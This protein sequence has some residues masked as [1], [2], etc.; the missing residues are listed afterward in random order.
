MRVRKRDG[1]LE[2][3][4]LDKV[5]YRL[6]TLSGN[7]KGLG[8]LSNIDPDI[9]ALDVVSRLYDSIPTTQIDEEAA[10]IAVSRTEH[11]E[12]LALASRIIISNSHRMTEECFSAVMEMLYDNVDELGDHFPI[13]NKDFI[14]LVRKH[15][16][17]LNFIPDYQLD[18]HLD[19]FGFK[20][21]ER[22]YLLK[23]KIKRGDKDKLELLPL[24]R[25][26]HMYLRVALALYR[27]DL[28]KVERAY[29]YMS[30]GLYTQA[31]PTMFNAGTSL[32]QLSSCFDED[33]LV[34]TTNRGAVKIKDICIGDKTITHT[35]KERKITQIH[36]NELNNREMYR[37]KVAKTKHVLVTGNHKLY[38]YNEASQEITWKAVEN[39]ELHDYVCTVLNVECLDVETEYGRMKFLKYE[40]KEIIDYKKQYVYT[41]GVEEDHS[42]TVEG[43]IVENCFLLHMEDSLEGIFKTMTDTALIS[44]SAGGIG[45]PISNIRAKGSFIR[46]TNGP[47]DGIIPM[48]KVFN[49]VGKYVNQGGKRKGSIALYVE[50]WHGD[51]FEFLDLRK[52]QGHEDLRARDLFLALWIPDLFMKQ[53]ESDGDWWL[54]CPDK[55]PGLTECYGDEFEE[56]YWKYVKDLRFIKKIKAQEL[57]K[58]ILDAQIETGN[59]YMVY[60]DAVNRKSNQKNIGMVKSSNLCVHGDTEILTDRGYF[61]IESLEGQNVKVWNGEEWSATIILKTGENQNLSKIVFSDGGHLVCTEYHKFYVKENDKEIQVSAYELKEGVELIRCVYPILTKEQ[62]KNDIPNRQE[63]SILV[64][65]IEKNYTV[66]DTYC[67]NEPKLHRGVFNGYL[68]G[69]CSEIVLHASKDEYGTCNLESIALPKFVVKTRKNAKPYFDHE[70]FHKVVKDTIESMNYVIDYNYYPVKETKKSNISHRPIGVGVQGLHD[71]YIK[72]RYPF[73]SQDARKLNKEIFETLYHACLEGSLEEAK[74]HGSYETFK[75]SPLSEGKFQFDLWADNDKDFKVD[76][77]ISSRYDW[78]ALREQIKEHGVRNSMLTT[79][80][81]TASTA[82]ILG[83]TEAIEPFDSCIF[84]RRVLAGEFTVMNKYLVKDLIELGLWSEDLKNEIILN[85]GS[86]QYIECIPEDIKKLYK[87]VWEISQKALIDQSAERGPFIDHTQSLNLFMGRPTIKKLSAMHLYSWKRGLKTGLYYLRS[88][89]Q[90]R[91]AA[92]SISKSP[93][94]IKASAV[95]SEEINESIESEKLMCSLLNRDECDMCSS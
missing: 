66:A 44:K 23:K 14:E 30:Q 65:S 34:F 40:C 68:T 16:T 26:Q 74:K 77:Y 64:K 39:L 31:S 12:Y 13:V 2:N 4:S 70:Y 63:Q 9:I 35:G 38:V 1:V 52:A 57:F 7:F 58:A 82:Q 36:K 24:E 87:T 86:I 90:T 71:V 27:D 55:C 91:S 17:K 88:K 29:N 81:P 21:L 54:M 32:Q 62:N 92:F 18:Y 95:F 69:Q 25:P 51:V 79:C 60:K 22:S 49:E 37:L 5:T 11:P 56:L 41:L 42:Y 8:K 75:G 20:T 33:T 84:K 3:V 45:I 72:M 89:P 53:V 19:Y 78:G 93:P 67:F 28:E 46:G 43:L 10:R 76:D 85:D 80:M 59:P 6:K 83:N 94:K 47:S 73:E 61:K 50:P 15:K 48:L